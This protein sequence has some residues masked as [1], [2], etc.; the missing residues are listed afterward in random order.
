MQ[1]ETKLGPLSAA[2]VIVSLTS[3]ARADG[4]EQAACDAAFS[5]SDISLRDHKLVAARDELRTCS[6]AVCGS[7][8]ADC[9]KQLAA[10]EARIPAVVFRAELAGQSVDAS[11]QMDQKPLVMQLDGRSV[12]VDPGSH[13]FTFTLGNGRKKEVR[14]T[15]VE[16]DNGQKVIA[17]FEATAETDKPRTDSTK[18]PPLAET[19]PFPYRT[20]GYATSAVGIVGLGLGA[21][22]GLVASGKKSDARCDSSNLCDDGS[23]LDSAR[24]AATVSTIGFIAGGVLLAAGVG[25][26]LFSP[27]NKASPAPAVGTLRVTPALGAGSGGVVLG[28]SF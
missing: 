16:S 3:V 15:V 4:D 21:V 5:S 6:R 13:L 28:S 14:T 8:A 10:M 19:K 27:S 17:V 1:I 24:S 25:I 26:V 2:L 12:D 18:P 7:M 23:A 22:F 20:V 9:S 11:V